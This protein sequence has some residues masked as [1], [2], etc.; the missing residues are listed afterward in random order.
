MRVR[1]EIVFKNGSS[2]LAME[3][4]IRKEK[5]RLNLQEIDP[6][7][8]LLQNNVTQSPNSKFENS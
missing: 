3:I 5:G 6:P 2:G 8:M 7:I 1:K 4:N